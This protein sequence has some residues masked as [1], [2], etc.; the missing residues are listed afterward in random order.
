[1]ET[2]VSISSDYFFSY[3][4]IK[5][6]FQNNS[7]VIY[8]I[9]VNLILYFLKFFSLHPGRKGR[10]VGQISL[11]SNI[12]LFLL[13]SSFWL[14]HYYT[15]RSTN[16]AKRKCDCCRKKGLIFARMNPNE[17]S[18]S[19]KMYSVLAW[20]LVT[21]FI[22]EFREKRNFGSCIKFVTLYPFFFFFVVFVC[23][24]NATRRKLIFV[25]K[26]DFP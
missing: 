3:L 17:I 2:H 24:K 25:V 8:V 9:L 13:F 19:E 7:T 21:N 5:H 6:V 18:R 15:F 26:W 22:G 23:H 4:L 1:M 14:H 20:T 12:T 10:E 11:W 16:W